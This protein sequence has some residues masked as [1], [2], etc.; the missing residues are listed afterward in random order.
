MGDY[1]QEGRNPACMRIRPCLRPCIPVVTTREYI[2]FMSSSQNFKLKLSFEFELKFVLVSKFRSF[3]ECPVLSF[4]SSFAFCG[5]LVS[6]S[7][8]FAIVL[9]VPTNGSQLQSTEMALRRSSRGRSG[10]GLVLRLK[11]VTRR[12]NSNS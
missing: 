9:T 11:I 4:R 12:F 3:C 5:S 7:I 10:K 1:F 8:K 2:K 6:F